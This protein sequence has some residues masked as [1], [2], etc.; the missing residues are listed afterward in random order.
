[1]VGIIGGADGPTAVIVTSSLTAIDA[2]PALMF[3]A[4]SIGVM[5]LARWLYHWYQER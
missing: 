3:L 4:A 1:M 2:I 5:I